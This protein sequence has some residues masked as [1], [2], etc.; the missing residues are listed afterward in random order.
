MHTHTLVALGLFSPW[1]LLLLDSPVCPGLRPHPQHWPWVWGRAWWCPLV[2]G[3]GLTSSSL[4]PQRDC[5][6]YIKILL[7]LNSTHLYVCGTGAFSPL[8]TYVVSAPPLRERPPFLPQGAVVQY[9]P[10]VQARAQRG[11]LVAVG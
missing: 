4:L 10:L 9:Q 2:A 11:S 1:R 8:C 6:N 3:L 7:P 5:Q